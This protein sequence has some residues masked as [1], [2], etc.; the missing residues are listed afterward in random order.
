MNGGRTPVRGSFGLMRRGGPVG[1]TID[2]SK[3]S[4]LGGGARYRQSLL[5]GVAATGNR[6]R[7]E[8]LRERSSRQHNRLAESLPTREESRASALLRAPRVLLAQLSIARQKSLHSGSHE[9]NGF[10]REPGWHP[11]LRHGVTLHKLQEW[12]SFGHPSFFDLD[13]LQKPCSLP[14]S[15]LENCIHGEG[16]STLYTKNAGG[17]PRPLIAASCEATASLLPRIEKA[18]HEER[19]ARVYSI[20]KSMLAG[21]LEEA[22]LKRTSQAR[23]HVISGH[24]GM[25]LE[26]V[27]LKLNYAKLSSKMEVPVVTRGFIPAD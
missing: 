11:S 7:G 2:A 22:L 14:S 6:T 1:E 16:S 13:A 4:V 20:V 25:R 15:G 17:I 27:C 9:Q 10:P 23:E 12:R 8:S 19:A 18:A 21:L 3:H 26:L 24:F 5:D